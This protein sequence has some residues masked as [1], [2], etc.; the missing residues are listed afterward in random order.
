[1]T[2]GI[3]AKTNGA[4]KRSHGASRCSESADDERNAALSLNKLAN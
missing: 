2:V 4:T 1:M 3:R